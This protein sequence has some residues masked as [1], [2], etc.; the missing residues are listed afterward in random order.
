MVTLL[1]RVNGAMGATFVQKRTANDPATGD[2][3]GY[4]AASVRGLSVG[5]AP[6]NDEAGLN[7]G[8]VRFMLTP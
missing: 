3:F 1:R 8:K 7:A 6:F 4:S 2:A 5:G